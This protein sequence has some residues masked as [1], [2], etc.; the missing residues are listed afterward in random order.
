MIFNETW[1]QVLDG[2]KTQTRRIRKSNDVEAWVAPGPLGQDRSRYI[3]N[4]KRNGRTLYWVG[5][6]YAVQAARG[7]KALFRVKLTK[8]EKQALHNIS[9]ADVK[10]EGFANLA[11]FIQAWDGL[12]P[13]GKR[14]A[15]N[16]QVWVL[17]IKRTHN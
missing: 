9:H 15:D 10:A 6:T 13:K 5:S 7:G 3:L 16:P 8:I 2:E 11:D 12:H 4:I 17:H 14:W 1:R